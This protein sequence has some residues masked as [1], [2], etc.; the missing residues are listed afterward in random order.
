MN[1]EGKFQCE[2]CDKNV[3]Y[4]HGKYEGKFLKG[5]KL[6]VCKICYDANHDGWNSFYENKLKKCLSK[7]FPFPPRNEKGLLPREF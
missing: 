4:S 1:E 3:H 5:Y 7:S 6:F 2:L